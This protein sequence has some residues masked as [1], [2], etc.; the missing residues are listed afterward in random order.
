[1]LKQNDRLII[2]LANMS[3]SAQK[4]QL[5][6]PHGQYTIRQLNHDNAIEAMTNPEG[7][8]IAKGQKLDITSAT[9]SLTLSPYEYVR[10]Q[11]E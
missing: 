2:L 8:R 5:N 7:Y 11:Q 1:V 6:V 10:L 4:V 9:S 3:P